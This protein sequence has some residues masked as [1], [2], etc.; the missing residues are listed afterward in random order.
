MRMIIV[1]VF[2]E[3]VAEHFNSSSRIRKSLEHFLR[4]GFPPFFRWSAEYLLTID[5][6]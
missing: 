3:Q 6:N 2:F 4:K 5:I 1:L